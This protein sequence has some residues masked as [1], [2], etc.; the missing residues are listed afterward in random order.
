[1]ANARAA[2]TNTV[3]NADHVRVFPGQ[4]GPVVAEVRRRAARRMLAANRNE[5]RIDADADQAPDRALGEAQDEERQ[6]DR[7]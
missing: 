2:A 4:L 6:E 3:P 1:M 5:K 7:R